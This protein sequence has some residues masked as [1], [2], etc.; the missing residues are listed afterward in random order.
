VRQVVGYDRLI[1]ERVYRQLTELYLALRL[2][3][4]CFRPSMKLLSKQREGKKVRCVYDSAKTPLQRLLLSGILTAQQQQELIEVAHALDPM[5]LFQ[6]VEQLQQAVFRYA[7]NVPPLISNT[8]SAPVRV[9]SVGYCMMGTVQFRGAH[10]IQQQDSIPCT[11]SRR[12]E[13]AS[14]AGGIPTKIPL[15]ESGNKLWPG[16][17]PTRNGAAATFSA[18]CSATPQDAISHCKSA[19]FSE[20]CA[21]SE[22]TSC[23]PLRSSGKKK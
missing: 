3:V 13:N 23:E 15:K 20:E 18:S 5:R 8:P 11:T 16:C 7:I 12:G 1:G 21:R 9:F 17:L 19:P 22:P 2:Y 4:N 14:R 10:P 6:Q